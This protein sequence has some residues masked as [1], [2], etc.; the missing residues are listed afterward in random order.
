MKFYCV[1]SKK[2]KYFIQNLNKNLNIFFQ[3]S[4]ITLEKVPCKIPELVKNKS[5][6]KGTEDKRNISSSKNKV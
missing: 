4:Q 6:K 1:S 2:K 3:L 5:T